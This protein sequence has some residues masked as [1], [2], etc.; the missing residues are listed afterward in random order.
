M[1]ESW[2]LGKSQNFCLTLS[3]ARSTEEVIELY[4]GDLGTARWLAS[5]DCEIATGESTLLRAG[6]LGGWAFCVEFENP[7]GSLDGVVRKL[8][9]NTETIILYHTAKAL[10]VFQY[11]VNGQLVESFEPGYLSSSWG[12]SKHEFS[13]KVHELIPSSSNAVTACLHVIS[14]HIGQPLTT[15]LLTGPLLSAVIDNPDR[16][17]LA[18]RAPGLRMTTPPGTDSTLGRRL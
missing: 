12:W 5:E 6:P 16:P 18:R 13:R 8:S 14:E 3:A 4:G 7:I 11:V 2:N 9:V 17:T 1:S 15:D 10:K